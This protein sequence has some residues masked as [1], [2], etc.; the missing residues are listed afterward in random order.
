MSLGKPITR[1]EF[2]KVSATAGG[3]LLI[4]ITI[5]VAANRAS[6][7]SDAG[8]LNAFVRIDRDNSVTVQVPRPEIGQGVRTSLPMILA[9]ELDVPLKLVRVEQAEI[10]PEFE[11]PELDPVA[12]GISSIPQMGQLPGSL[13]VMCGCIAHV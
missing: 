2:L 12:T 4:G 13:R 5:P 8:V 10:A 1:R 9:D 11:D 3:G 6:A 7:G